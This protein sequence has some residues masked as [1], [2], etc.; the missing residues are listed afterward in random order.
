[1]TE[2]RAPRVTRADFDRLEAK[3][4]QINAK[5]DRILNGPGTQ[6]TSRQGVIIDGDRRFLP[7]TGW[8]TPS[9]LSPTAQAALAQ[10]ESEN[11]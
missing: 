10:L 3:T 4:D 6:P 2:Q 11:Q 8:D 5:L 7:G 9:E 1:M